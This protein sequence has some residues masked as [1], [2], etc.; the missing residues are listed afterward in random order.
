VQADGSLISK[1][2]EAELGPDGS[3]IEAAAEVIDAEIEEEGGDSGDTG[4]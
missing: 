3:F 2:V 4:D 1:V